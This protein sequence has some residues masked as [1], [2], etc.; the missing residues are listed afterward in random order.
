MLLLL[1]FFFYKNKII[2]KKNKKN[3]HFDSINKINIKLRKE[4][5]QIFFCFCSVCVFSHWGLRSS[6]FLSPTDDKLKGMDRSSTVIAKDPEGKNKL[7]NH[8]PN[9]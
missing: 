4:Y 5:P 6:I 2:I 1:F 8:N 7:N 9:Y 3:K